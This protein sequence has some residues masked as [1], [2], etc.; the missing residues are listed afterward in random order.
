MAPRDI[1][2]SLSRTSIAIAALMIAVSVI[3]GLS[4]MVGSF[5]QT[6]EIWLEQ[7]L[8]ADIYLSPPTTTNASDN[9]FVAPDVMEA[10][11][12]WPGVERGVSARS[13]EIF[14][15]DWRNRLTPLRS[16]TTCRTESADI[17]V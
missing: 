2:R 13:V 3:I 12:A 6:V 4:I 14:A 1:I 5:R 7:T 9:G 8:R 11:L 10:A 17:L 16:V 15:P